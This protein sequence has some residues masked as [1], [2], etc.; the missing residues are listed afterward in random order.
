MF[1]RHV[2]NRLHLDHQATLAL[3]SN[4]Q[5]TLASG[6]EDPV[7]MRRAAA[8]LEHE[9]A[10]HFELEEK[11]LFPRLAAAGEGDI[12]ELLTEEHAVI[13]AAGKRFI[14]LAR[15]NASLREL[16]PLGLELAER[17]FAHVHK[18]E[19]GLVPL[20]EDVLDDEADEALSLAYAS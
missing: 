12:G 7:L 6:R 17:I 5:A 1:K 15:G 14:E 13:R 16:R 18:E 3:W 8:A 4:V 2:C 19:L 10:T 20:V 9:L 11:E